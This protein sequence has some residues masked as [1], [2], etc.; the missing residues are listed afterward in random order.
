MNFVNL[1]PHELNIYNR[2]GEHVTD[3]EPS[4]DTVRVDVSRDVV[5]EIGDIPILET[6]YGEVDGLPEPEEG[7]VYIVSGF[8][9][10]HPSVESR[11]DVY[12]PGELVRDDEGNPI[13]CKGLNR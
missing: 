10:T 2:D 5:D 1:T 3:I 12:S 8:V 11:E 4:G 6:E 9:K 13:G 7:V